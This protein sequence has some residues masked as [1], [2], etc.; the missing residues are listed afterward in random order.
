MKG[1]IFVASIL[2]ALSL[3]ARGEVLVCHVTDPTGTPLNV[4]TVPGGET[5]VDTLK[6]GTPV[7]I[8]D[9]KNKWAYIGLLS[10]E[11][12]MPKGDKSIAPTGWV[13]R[14]YLD[15]SGHV[16]SKTAEKTLSVG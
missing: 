6:N 7:T 15:C 10:E 12:E 11:S 3:P 1:P 8:I 13:Y 5:I 4:R 9:T 2:S 14:E 16:A